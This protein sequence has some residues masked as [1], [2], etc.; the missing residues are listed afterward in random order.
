MRKR[1]LAW[2]THQQLCHA[3]LCH[4]AARGA[5]GVESVGPGG[6]AFQCIS[7]NKLRFFMWFEGYGDGARMP[8]PRGDGAG[9][10]GGGGGLA[11]PC[12]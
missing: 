4:D 7:Q 10:G 3:P 8:A 1:V 12:G 9:Q 6:E 2:Q 11:C 5:A